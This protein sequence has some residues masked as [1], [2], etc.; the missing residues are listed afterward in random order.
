[1]SP[2]KRIFNRMTGQ[3]AG[4]SGPQLLRAFGKLPSSREFLQLR[5]GQGPGKIGQDWIRDGHEEWVR[6]REGHRRGQIVPFSYFLDLPELGCQSLIACVWNSQDG[7]APPRSFPFVLYVVCTAPAAEEWLDRFLWCEHYRPQFEE[8]FKSLSNGETNL[9]DLEGYELR[10]PSQQEVDPD[11]CAAAASQIELRIWLEAMLPALHCD[12]AENCLGM[13]TALADKWRAHASDSGIA[14][15]LPLSRQWPYQPQVAAWLKWLAAQLTG[16][17]HELT[18]LFV[19][20]DVPQAEP[21]VTITTRP[22]CPADFHFLTSNTASYPSV[23]DA[24]SCRDPSST[25]AAQGSPERLSR[26]AS[27]WDWATAEPRNPS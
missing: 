2:L 18:G 14:V 3:D 13:L 22:T 15:R 11:G 8:L 9:R 19:P 20:L 16:S 17:P 7:A 25:P 6:R 21:A 4:D 24:T 10:L 23:D 12:S 5:A 27:L 1:M 26:T